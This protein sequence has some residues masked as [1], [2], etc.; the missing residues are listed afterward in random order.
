MDLKYLAS[1]QH[2]LS[3]V[4]ALPPS[5][6]QDVIDMECDETLEDEP[7][8][9]TVLPPSGRSIYRPVARHQQQQTDQV[10]TCD[11]GCMFRLHREQIE[12]VAI[13]TTHVTP[14]FERLTTKTHESEMNV[15]ALSNKLCSECTISSSPCKQ[16]AYVFP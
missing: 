5:V 7:V 11:C 16:T 14:C 10:Y 9:F 13:C 8:Y 6:L 2:E 3:E 4:F 12:S 15:E 1:I